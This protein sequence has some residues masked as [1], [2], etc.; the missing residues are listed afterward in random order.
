MA[1]IKNRDEKEFKKELHKAKYK[2]FQFSV[3][4]SKENWNDENRLK[5]SVVNVETMGRDN[6][7]KYIERLK[8]DIEALKL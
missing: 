1:E 8:K 4:T 3:K 5:V 6:L 7:R 2:Q